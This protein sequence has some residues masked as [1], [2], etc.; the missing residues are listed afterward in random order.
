MNYDYLIFLIGNKYEE[1]S[2]SAHLWAL[3]KDPMKTP[4]HTD[5]ADNIK[6]AIQK[7]ESGAEDD[8]VGSVIYDQVTESRLAT[9]IW[10]KG[11]H[12]EE[13]LQMVDHGGGHVNAP[14]N[15]RRNTRRSRDGFKE[16]R[17]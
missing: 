4:G 10:R 17:E 16:P 5:N 15:D 1:G 12:G 3:A 6:E 2:L 9:F 8:P 14:E 13:V 11:D 7:A